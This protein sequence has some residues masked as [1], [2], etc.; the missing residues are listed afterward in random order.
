MRVS[1]PNCLQVLYGLKKDKEYVNGNLNKRL[2]RRSEHAHILVPVL[3][4]KPLSGINDKEIELAQQMVFDFP[5][6]HM[7]L[8]PYS[9]SA[10]Q[11]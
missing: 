3:K 11:R 1:N 4:G 6:Y 9:S 7:V 2:F 5:T 8:N 10:H